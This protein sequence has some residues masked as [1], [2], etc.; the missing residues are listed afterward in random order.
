[1]SSRSAQTRSDNDDDIHS[2]KRFSF[3]G[4]FNGKQNSNKSEM[5]LLTQGRIPVFS[6]TSNIVL[7]EFG[8]VL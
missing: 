2:I 3:E 8:S 1:M 6:V 5:K 7:I 4:P